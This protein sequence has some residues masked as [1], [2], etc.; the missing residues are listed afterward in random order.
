MGAF[1]MDARISLR[2]TVETWYFY[3]VVAGRKSPHLGSQNVACIVLGRRSH[4]R[5]N[6]RVSVG[7]MVFFFFLDHPISVDKVI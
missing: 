5:S 2:S 1:C 3:S 6:W 7:Q 4:V